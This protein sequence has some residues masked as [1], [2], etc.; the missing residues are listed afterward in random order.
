MGKYDKIYMD[1]F[2]Y[3]K[4]CSMDNN[5]IE[6][7]QEEASRY[8]LTPSL[9]KEILYE[10]KKKIVEKKDLITVANKED[11]K[12]SKKQVKIKELLKIV[13]SYE[14]S[15]CVMN[16]DE[17]KIIVYK[18]D[19]YV[20]LHVC[21][22]ALTLRNKILLVQN[23]FMFGVNEVLIK[24]IETIFNEYKISNLITH[25]NDY[26]AKEIIS[27]KKMF[28][29]III[30][31]DTTMYQQLQDEEGIEVKYYP[32]N[33]ICI[34]SDN[35]E[36]NKLQEAIFIYANENQYEM[37]V[38]YED[39]VED[40]IHEINANDFIDTAILLTKNAESEEL[41]K[42]M[43]ENKQVYVNDNPFKREVGKIYN[44]LV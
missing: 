14:N 8:A 30:I 7:L 11:I 34:Y 44:Y 39:N 25:S 41:F 35:T 21:L 12:V 15:E 22:Q 28:D 10:L 6:S 20:T 17:R 23:N 27:F 5:Q 37:E 36:F 31:G 13:E 42:V 26:D 29:Q 9:L 18:G 2:N 16:S 32:Y 3:K 24:I 40:V 19:P 4:G 33:N 1:N 38:L 43:I